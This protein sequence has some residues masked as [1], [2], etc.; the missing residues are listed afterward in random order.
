MNRPAKQSDVVI[1][2]A[3]PAGL[4][5]A[6]GLA[7]RGVDFIILD[8]LPD[9]QNTSRAAVIHAGT[10]NAL[11]PLGVADRL[12]AQGIRVTGF[13][14][15]D[16]ER[17]LLHADFG[18]LRDAPP[19][20]LM[21]PQDESEAILT[22]RLS[23]LGHRVLRPLLAERIE[24]AADAATVVL[25]DGRRIGARF[26]VGADGQDSTIRKQAGIGFPGKTH[27]SFMLA[28]VR[29]DWPIP[30]DE[31]TL[32]FSVGGTLVVAPMSRDR[33]RV[34]AQC[35]DAPAEPAV[36]DVQAVIDAR[37]PGRGARVREILWGSRF[38][39]HHRMAD[40]FRAGPVLLLGDAAHVHSPAGGQGMN[41]GLRDAVAL[42]DALAAALREGRESALDDY[43][44]ARMAAARE[45]LRMTDRLT[46]IATL[47]PR[48]LRMLRNL[49]IRK[50]S[51]LPAWRRYVARRL[52]GTR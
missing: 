44:A 15:R 43:A 12:I 45:I 40:R 34:V 28:D 36:P 41:L 31:V 14:A 10:L 1:V 38:R 19:F 30:K 9:A 2:G 23:G 7:Q 13:R 33:Y 8:A 42:A 17:V 3:G 51:T 16:R 37:G 50:A 5:L 39:V 21:I 35:P 48:A 49:V 11:A 24:T 18:E 46:A 47:R 20:A 29:M 22:E 25:A 26:V 52:A 27:G 32:F 4:A 6:I